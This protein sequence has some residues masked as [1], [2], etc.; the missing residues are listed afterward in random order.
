MRIRMVK[1][2]KADGSPC[3]KCADVEKRLSDAGLLHR[4]D[5]IIIADEN[6][7][8]SDGMQLAREFDVATAPFFIVEDDTGE[9]TVYT[10]YFK[11]LKEVLEKG[12][13]T[14]RKSA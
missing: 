14:D 1:K 7:P 12:P 4:I 11:F 13:A 10:V 9:A 5:Q 2:L 6:D 8:T 3:R